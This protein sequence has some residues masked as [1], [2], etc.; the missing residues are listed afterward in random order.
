[1]SVT[2]IDHS[3]LLG[4]TAGAEWRFTGTSSLNV[5]RADFRRS[6]P[7]RPFYVMSRKKSHPGQRLFG[8]SIRVLEVVAVDRYVVHRT[9][10][11]WLL[12]LEGQHLSVLLPAADRPHFTVG[13]LGTRRIASGL[14]KNM[15]S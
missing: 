9:E 11:G 10:N 14:I 6:G 8:K 7:D 1:M 5:F 2:V 12:E 4:T 13:T 3:V 15:P